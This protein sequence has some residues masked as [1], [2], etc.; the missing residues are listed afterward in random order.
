MEGFYNGHR[1]HATPG[2]RTRLK[3]EEEKLD[4]R[5]RAVQGEPPGSSTASGQ[6]V[7]AP[8]IHPQH[9]PSQRIPM[10]LGTS[11]TL[12]C[13]LTVSLSVG[14]ISCGSGDS[15]ETQAGAN[16]T[17]VD[18]SG[19]SVSGG[20][21]KVEIPAGAL[22]TGTDIGV[23]AV[24]LSALA[25]LPAVISA[26]GSAIA[27]TPHGTTFQTPVT[28]TLPHDGSGDVVLRLDDEADTTWEVVSSAVFAGSEAKVTTSTFSIYVV[29]SQCQPYCAKVE[30]LCGSTLTQGTC[31]STCSTRASKPL[32]QSLCQTQFDAVRQCYSSQTLAT[33]FDCAS[34]AP[35]DTTCATERSAI[36]GCLLA[37]GDPCYT[38]AGDDWTATLIPEDPSQEQ[39]A[40]A[41]FV[42]TPGDPT[43]LT[44]NI[45]FSAPNAAPPIT[46]AF[47]PVIQGKFTLADK[48]I[49]L[50]SDPSESSFTCI[51]ADREL[52]LYWLVQAMSNGNKLESIDLTVKSNPSSP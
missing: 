9:D 42:P 17:R 31:Q 28:L 5:S 2:Y 47:D 41:T 49:D 43:T 10:R 40:P 52:H 36:S 20:G 7:R 26:A 14:A 30:A 32:E 27:F 18:A 11:A 38:F 33:A 15:S 16:A 50:F 1:L 8:R 3:M 22:A 44:L 19:G 48:M 4:M 39:S 46:V 12:L 45:Q 13:A 24:D 51:G 37:S 21:A 35:A 25:A 6:A 23:A 29:A 34:G